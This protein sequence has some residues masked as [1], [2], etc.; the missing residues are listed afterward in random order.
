MEMNVFCFVVLV[1]FYHWFFF[2]FL[3]S[4]TTSTANTQE[5][6]I[7]Q[8]RHGM[9]W[10]KKNKK[11]EKQQQHSIFSLE[12]SVCVLTV[13][14][15]SNRNDTPMAASAAAATENAKRTHHKKESTRKSYNKISDKYEYNYSNMIENKNVWFSFCLWCFRLCC[16]SLSARK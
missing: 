2:I 4:K 9:K 13:P 12:S 14:F 3:L 6:D 5:V 7:G 1:L 8:H 11:I 16:L 15:V 10:R